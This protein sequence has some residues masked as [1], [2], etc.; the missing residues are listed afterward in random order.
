MLASIG[1]PCDL[2][3]SPKDPR[4]LEGAFRLKNHVVTQIS[5][6]SRYTHLVYASSHFTPKVLAQ[7]L[8]QLPHLSQIFVI[9]ST[10]PESTWAPQKIHDFLKIPFFVVPRDHQ[11][12]LI[13]QEAFAEDRL[14]S[15]IQPALSLR[16]TQVESFPSDL[17]ALSKWTA[18]NFDFAWGSPPGLIP[19]IG[20]VF[21]KAS[22][23]LS[24]NAWLALF[25]QLD[26]VIVPIELSSSFYEAQPQYD[27]REPMSLISKMDCNFVFSDNG[28]LLS[29]LT[30]V[31]F[32]FARG[33]PNLDNVLKHVREMLREKDILPATLRQ[34]KLENQLEAKNLLYFRDQ[35]FPDLRDMIDH[36][37]ADGQLPSLKPVI[38]LILMRS[39]QPSL[40]KFHPDQLN[41]GLETTIRRHGIPMEITTITNQDFLRNP[42][43]LFSFIGKMDAVVTNRLHGVVLSLRR[44][45]PIIAFDNI[46]GGAKVSSQAK[47][48]GWPLVY[49]PRSDHVRNDSLQIYLDTNLPLVLSHKFAHLAHELQIDVTQRFHASL[50]DLSRCLRDFIAD[51][52]SLVVLYDSSTQRNHL[53]SEKAKP[54]F[55]ES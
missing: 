21:E 33:K 13:A 38:G 32:H 25:G 19:V 24:R 46:L 3:L 6:H 41:D 10:L 8:P 34:A 35:L 9:S 15:L 11:E 42:G 36:Y 2:L 22:P 45:V 52:S 48:L 54:S 23:L 20:F 40:G 37:Q 51:P 14:F 4:V 50:K 28:A 30:G 18:S 55:Y 12:G 1:L 49:V 16:A 47:Y 39:P 27:L 7:Y 31:P 43:A 53:Y 29:L 44:G 17:D 5:P 26:V